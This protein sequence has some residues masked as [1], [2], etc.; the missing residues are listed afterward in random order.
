MANIEDATANVADITSR[1]NT[2]SIRR[3]IDNVER[4]SKDAVAIADDAAAVTSG[5]MRVASDNNLKRIE[6]ILNRLDSA[7]VELEGTMQAANRATVKMETAINED[8]MVMVSEFLADLRT[9]QRDIGQIAATGI[10]TS[11]NLYAISE[12][13]ED[14]LAGFL[15]RMEAAAL[16]IEEMTA[17]LR[18]DPSLIIRGSE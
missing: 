18:D 11:E 4:V 17:R 14:R 1:E 10:E 12:F 6:T 15:Q 3:T 8:N 16:N 7:A 13:S 2:E 9:L 5:V